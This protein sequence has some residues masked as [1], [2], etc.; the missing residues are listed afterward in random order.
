MSSADFSKPL[1]ALA[2]TDPYRVLG[3]DRRAG[4]GEIKRAYFQ[5]V[6]QFSPESAPEK[7]QEIRRAYEQLRTPE[8]RARVD[9]FL[10][11]PPPDIPNRRRA[12]YDLRVHPADLL[13]LTLEMAAKPKM[14]DFRS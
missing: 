9:L 12:S 2:A 13:T 7:F 10:I 1:L 5:L 11:Q 6:R 14:Q 3:I 4:D 8:S